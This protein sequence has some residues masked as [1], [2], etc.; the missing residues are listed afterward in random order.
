[1][2]K[3]KLSLKKEIISDL[4]ANKVK[5]GGNNPRETFTGC[6]AKYTDDCPSGPKCT[7]EC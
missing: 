6:P 5:G 4:E 3:L 2:R 7:L 1:M